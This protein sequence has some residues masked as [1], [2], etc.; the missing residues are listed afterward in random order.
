MR[1]LAWGWVNPGDT[2][3]S[4]SDRAWWG[5]TYQHPLWEP[6]ATY[7]DQL[8]R[9]GHEPAAWAF[10]A[11]LAKA[12]EAELARSLPAAVQAMSLVQAHPHPEYIIP[13][14]AGQL[15]IPN[16]SAAPSARPAPAAQ[17]APKKSG[18]PWW[19]L[20][21]LLLDGNKRRKR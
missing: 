12:D 8:E 1:L 14:A 3:K 11:D 19:I 2:L 17:A 18:F 15:P 10:D 5:K 4:A 9:A 21:L 6:L 20:L 13:A 7:I 16:P